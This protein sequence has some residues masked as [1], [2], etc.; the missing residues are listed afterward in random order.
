MFMKVSIGVLIFLI[1]IIVL[2]IPI[3]IIYYKLRMSS[4][5]HL[6]TINMVKGWL[7]VLAVVSLIFALFLFFFMYFN[8]AISGTCFYMNELLVDENFYENH[9]AD[10]NVENED[11][12]NIL[13]NCFVESTASFSHFFNK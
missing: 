4:D 8:L 10:L 6:W 7:V 1:V 11:V 3:F 13:K 12:V 2:F 5:H 9:Q